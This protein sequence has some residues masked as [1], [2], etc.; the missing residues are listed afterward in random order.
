MAIS[1]RFH[2]EEATVYIANEFMQ[3]QYGLGEYMPT[4]VH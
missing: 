3:M 1:S 2:L 4:S